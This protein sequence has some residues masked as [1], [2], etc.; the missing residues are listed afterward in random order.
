MKKSDVYK[1]QNSAE[2]RNSL[3]APLAGGNSLYDVNN[4][5]NNNN[6]SHLSGL[7]AP[8]IGKIA[9]IQQQQQLLQQQQQQLQ[10][11]EFNNSKTGLNTLLSSSMQFSKGKLNNLN[12][13]NSNLNGG[14]TMSMSNVFPDE[15]NLSS[16][17]DNSSFLLSLQRNVEK[18][19]KPVAGSQFRLPVPTN[20]RCEYCIDSE[21]SLKKSKEIIRGLKLQISRLEDKYIGLKKSKTSEPNFDVD[22]EMLSEDAQELK[23]L[24]EQL[25]ARCDSQEL[26]ISKL[27]KSLNREKLMVDEG[28]E[29]IEILLK[30]LSGIESDLNTCNLNHSTVVKSKDENI[31]HLTDQL[32]ELTKKLNEIQSEMKQNSRNKE[33]EI[34]IYDLTAELEKMKKDYASAFEKNKKLNLR[35]ANL[36]DLEKSTSDALQKLKTDYANM[37]TEFKSTTNELNSLARQKCVA[38]S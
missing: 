20:D 8:L 3:T 16:T 23:I 28:K 5:N 9:S 19:Q 11:P 31:T 37:E 18:S 1:K 4:S 6:N 7:G 33:S 15:T 14:F 22:G 12:G 36:E 24:K 32:N 27:K 30:K 13:S 35:V 17:E 10:Q 2:F 21:K 38:K 26:E 25:Q 29:N 34:K